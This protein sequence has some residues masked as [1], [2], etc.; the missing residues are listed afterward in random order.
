MS[1]PESSSASKKISSLT[2]CR[3][4]G[5]K[6]K[7]LGSPLH[8]NLEKKIKLSNETKLLEKS[9]S[10]KNNPDECVSDNKLPIHIRIIEKQKKIEELNSQL[11]NSDQVVK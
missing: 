1:N 6:R 3:R 8:S 2:P 11:K 10:N 9:L 4:I 7:S 5:L